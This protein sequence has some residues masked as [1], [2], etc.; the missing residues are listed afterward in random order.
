MH[1][2]L[3]VNSVILE[4]RTHV[5]T[6]FSILNHQRNNIQTFDPRLIGHP[7]KVQL[8]FI[9]GTNSLV[10]KLNLMSLLHCKALSFIT[11][12]QS[13]QKQIIFS[14]NLFF[15]YNPILVT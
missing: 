11:Q 6:T 4:N 5:H 1:V 13:C 14:D 8:K 9:V 15:K 7:H 12:V 2:I 10:W 3:V